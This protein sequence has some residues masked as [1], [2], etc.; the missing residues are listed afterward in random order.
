MP[1]PK[2]KFYSFPVQTDFAIG[3]QR[4]NE[5]TSSV[6]FDGREENIEEWLEKTRKESFEAA[7]TKAEGL[8]EGLKGWDNCVKGDVSHGKCAGCAE[9]KGWNAALK[10]ALSK[11]K[12]L[13][14]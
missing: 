3:Y 1:N 5:H 9:R 13:K 10:S 11:L 12:E 2:L 7:L 14:G 8:L 6:P 4:G